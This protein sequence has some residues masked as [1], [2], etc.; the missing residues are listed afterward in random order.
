MNTSVSVLSCLH[1][2]SCLHASRGKLRFNIVSND[3]LLRSPHIINTSNRTG[4]HSPS[5][6][7]DYNA[8]CSFIRNDDEDLKWRQNLHPFSSLLYK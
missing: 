5:D 2:S 6:K 8:K 7:P 1:E 3:S 4:S